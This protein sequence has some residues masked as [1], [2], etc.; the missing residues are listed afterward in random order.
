MGIFLD[1]VI[2]HVS[3]NLLKALWKNLQSS[4]SQEFQVLVLG[5]MSERVEPASVRLD[6][7]N[8]LL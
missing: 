5:G 6:L 7:R 8:L 4:K 2:W 1:E 3:F